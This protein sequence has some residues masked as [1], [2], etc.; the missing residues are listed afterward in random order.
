[1]ALVLIETERLRLRP[2][3]SRDASVFAQYRAEPAVAVYQS[4]EGMTLPE[5]RRFIDE[6][7][8]LPFGRHDQWSQ[9]GIAERATDE[10]VGDVG[11]CIRSPGRTAEIGFSIVPS[12]QRRGYAAEACRAIIGLLFAVPSMQSIEAIVD[13][14][15]SSAIALVQRLGMQLERTEQAL[16]KGQICDEHHFVLARASSRA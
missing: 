16:F 1:M 7:S 14:R 15:N 6:Q 3:A 8:D 5:A 9:L 13:A 2:L 4:W 12:A 11:I 10:L